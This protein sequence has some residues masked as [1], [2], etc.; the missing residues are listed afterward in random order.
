MKKSVLFALMAVMAFCF[1]GCKEQSSFEVKDISTKA[2]IMGKVI[3]ITG[4]DKSYNDV[5]SNLSGKT[6]V[7]EISNSDLSPNG[8]ANGYTTLTVVTDT[9]G[10]YSIE[11]PTVRDGANVTVR[12][13]D[14]TGQYSEETSSGEYKYSSVIYSASPKNVNIEPDQI[15]KC[16]L[17]YYKN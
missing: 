14:Y 2:T 12:V 16:D 1:T 10:D 13:A 8:N 7:I 11:I 5:K 3:A 9:E 17:T 15:K 4:R 6:V